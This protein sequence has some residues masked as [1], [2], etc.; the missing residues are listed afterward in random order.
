MRRRT[1][2]KEIIE[3][4]RMLTKRVSF[5]AGEEKELYMGALYMQCFGQ[6]Q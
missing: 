6:N 4:A 3:K 5:L 2:P 1:I